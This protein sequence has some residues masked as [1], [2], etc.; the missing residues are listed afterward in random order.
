MT[1]SERDNGIDERG[2]AC[3]ERVVMYLL[4]EEVD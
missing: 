3:V 4:Y 2:P 1:V